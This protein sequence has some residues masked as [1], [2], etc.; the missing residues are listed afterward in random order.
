METIEKITIRCFFLGM[1]L[2]L[3]W[4]SLCKTGD[5]VYIFGAE[6]FDV[7]IPKVKIINYC[8]LMFTK[9]CVFLFFLIPYI[10]CKWVGKESAS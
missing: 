3:I 6:W 9:I 10:G 8:G 2:I 5:W 4:S 1:V 7:L